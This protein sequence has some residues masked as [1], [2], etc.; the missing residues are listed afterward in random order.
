MRQLWIGILCL[1]NLIVAAQWQPAGKW[2]GISEDIKAT[3]APIIRR[4]FALNKAIKQANI[5]V[6]GVG[7]HKTQVN[8]MPVTNAVLEQAFTRYD[9]RLEYQTYDVTDLLK[10]G[11]NA[12]SIELGN[13]WYNMQTMTIWGFDRMPWRKSPRVML[14][15]EIE[16][17]DGTNEV[18]STDKN[19]KANTGAS[20]FNSLI[21]G[22][23]YDARREHPGWKLANY[24]DKNWNAAIEVTSPGGS[25]NPQDMPSVAVIRKIKAVSLKRLDSD[26]YL[27]DFG[28]NFAGVVTL[29]VSGNAGDSAILCYD[30]SLDSSGRLD[31]KRNS[32]HVIDPPSAPKFQT[33]IYILKGDKQEIFTPRFT[34]HGFQYVE[35]RTTGS[36]KLKKNSLKGLFYS[37]DFETVGSFKSSDPLLNKMY[38]AAIRG[39]R[40][41]FVGIPTDCPQRE[42]MGW[43][44]DGHIGMEMGLYLYDAASAYR[45]WLRDIMDTQ[46]ENGQLAAIAP[47]DR[48]GYTWIDPQDRDFG[49]GWGGALPIGTWYLYLYGA[50]T[51]V[52]RENYP[53]I[54]KYA[55]YLLTMSKD[56][57]YQ[58]GLP[59]WLS[60]IP[61]PK[62]VT[63]TGYYYQS[64]LLTSKMAGV[65]GLQEDQ[66]QYARVAESIKE[67]YNDKYFSNQ[68]LSYK[69]SML[70][71]Q[72]SP[73]FLGLTP[74]ENRPAVI[75][76]AVAKTKQDSYR[77]NLGMMSAKYALPVLSE[78]DPDVAYRLLTNTAPGGWAER[79]S[80]RA[81]TYPEHWD[82]SASLNHVWM[83][84]FVA[85]L[86][87]GL[88]GIRPREDAPGFRKFI[89]HPVFPK[90]LNWIA[91][92]HQTRYGKIIVSWKRSGNQVKLKIIVPIG[93][94]A[95]L[96]V[97]TLE[98]TLQPGTY[99]FKVNS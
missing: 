72:L 31:R 86:Y 47:T 83:G 63:N 40:S 6:C 85:W 39:Y 62:H 20:I 35:V 44:A 4:V 74:A 56:G 71:A 18:I 84:S 53:S 88:A 5:L 30:E 37:S 58:T 89:I 27:Y 73:V 3:D 76:A 26:N 2:I 95:D 15:I 64:V 66:L 13:G 25:L 29:T 93:T 19:W 92:E 22:E 67:A 7:Y 21:A 9:K 60:P 54:R 87:S 10:K 41:N 78:A 16:Y 24:D 43:M 75:R 23:V 1:S 8:G 98:Q 81:T 99:E 90:D 55:D 42:K 68:S 77:A 82:A 61:T 51:T 33:D 91:A 49:P 12:V 32:G 97:P 38:E 34:Y 69:D 52:V 59:D 48:V 70:A 45:K 28:E 36:V 17:V 96:Q 94:E 79:I 80:K 65:L 14:D 11:E 50:D 57:I 46:K